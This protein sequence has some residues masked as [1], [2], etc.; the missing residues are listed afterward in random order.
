MQKQKLLV[1]VVLAFMWIYQLGN[2][3]VLSQQSVQNEVIYGHLSG[4]FSKTS[5]MHENVNL[6]ANQLDSSMTNL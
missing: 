5:I 3:E 4:N 6:T 2:W 1:R